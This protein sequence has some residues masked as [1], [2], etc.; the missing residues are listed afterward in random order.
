[1]IKEFRPTIFDMRKSSVQRVGG[2]T[3]RAT[4]YDKIKPT[5]KLDD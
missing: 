4:A 3:F 1:M 2:G 5:R